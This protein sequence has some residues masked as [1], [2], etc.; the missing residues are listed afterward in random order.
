MRAFHGDRVQLGTRIPQAL[1]RA[2]R[3]HAIERSL[4]LGAFVT[5]ALREHLARCQS[6]GDQKRGRDTPQVTLARRLRGA[7]RRG[8]T[9]S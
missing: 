2:I 3:L 9:E 6:A 5:E 8:V 1:H 7:Q 4:S